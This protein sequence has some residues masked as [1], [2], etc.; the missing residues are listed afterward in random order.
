MKTSNV[1]SQGIENKRNWIHTAIHQMKSR[2]ALK[3]SAFVFCVR[4]S[5]LL[6]EAI[7]TKHVINFGLVALSTNGGSPVG[8]EQ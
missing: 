5:W 8:G 6:A 3:P 2:G 1:I 7:Q 4:I